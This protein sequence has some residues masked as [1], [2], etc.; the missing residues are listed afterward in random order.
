MT[1][2]RLTPRAT[3][4]LA[5]TLEKKVLAYTMA[6]GAAGVSLLALSQSAQAK[7]IYTPTHQAVAKHSALSIDLNGDGITDFKASNL[8]S[9]VDVL[10]AK[11]IRDT[12]G[13]SFTFA[14]IRLYPGVKSN[15]VWGTAGFQS[16]LS[17]G[18]TLSSKGKFNQ[19][20]GF[21]GA[22]S[23]NQ[24]VVGQTYKGPWAP[25]GGTVT[26]KY[27]GLKFMINGQVH[28]GWA[29]FNVKIRSAE[30]TGSQ[31]ILTGYAYETVP[32]KPIVTGKT[33]GPDV[34]T[35]PPAT[36]GHLALGS[37]RH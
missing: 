5:E 25:A 1:Q 32:N 37:A 10:G 30:S 12:N 11:V 14:L 19:N 17:K 29:R 8:S 18:V 22:V 24:V 2:P 16:A 13:T 31:A 7:I 36:L 27:V 4:A 26:N 34:E 23:S 33:T 28:F 35:M 15:R 20:Y 21:M 9:D 3:S 6:A